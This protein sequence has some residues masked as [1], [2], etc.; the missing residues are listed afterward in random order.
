MGVIGQEL[1]G[2]QCGVE[3]GGEACRNNCNLMFS[4]VGASLNFPTWDPWTIIYHAIG[5]ASVARG[6]RPGNY[7]FL[8]TFNPTFM[9][10]ISDFFG[11]TRLWVLFRATVN[12][13]LRDG[14]CRR[15]VMCSQ[16]GKS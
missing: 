9:L 12:Q 10:K 3:S 1:A 7:S 13:N 4:R 6:G 2:L 14:K 11:A 15:V 8:V 16:V 5:T